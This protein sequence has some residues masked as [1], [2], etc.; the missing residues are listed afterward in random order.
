MFGVC[1]FFVFEM[2]EVNRIKWDGTWEDGL[3]GFV[4]SEV[5]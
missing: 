3:Y 2:K 5:F 4:G 1:V